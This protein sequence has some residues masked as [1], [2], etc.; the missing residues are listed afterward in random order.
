MH[1]YFDVQS[2]IKTVWTQKSFFFGLYRIVIEK[3]TNQNLRSKCIE[4]KSFAFMCTIC[5][6]G[7][8]GANLHRV[9]IIC[10]TSN[11]GAN[12][13]RV[14]I[15]KTPFRC[16][17]YTW[18]QMVHTNTA[19]SR[20]PTIYVSSINMK[21]GGIVLCFKLNHSEYVYEIT[22]KWVRNDLVTK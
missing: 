7:G 14:Q 1:S 4:I 20:V 6:G 5:T 12:L 21:R 19:F 8:V 16:P 2:A 13:H 17:K 10:T 15:L 3:A 22:K 11:V 18:V 9:L